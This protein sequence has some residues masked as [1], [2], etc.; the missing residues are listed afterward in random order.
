MKNLLFLLVFLAPSLLQGQVA[1]DSVALRQVDSLLQVVF[2]LNSNRGFD[3]ALQILDSI[4]FSVIEKAGRESVQ[5][6]TWLLHRGFIPLSKGDNKGSEK[7]LLE[8]ESIH[9]H[10]LQERHPD[11]FKVLYRLG[12]FVY[13]R[14]NDSL[15]ESY[16]MR[17]KAF[18]E[19]IDRRKQIEYSRVLGALGNFYAQT[20]KLDRA[21]VIMLESLASIEAMKGRENT[22]YTLALENL[23]KIYTK[24]NRFPEA[25]AKLTE[26]R[27]IKAKTLGTAHPDYAYCLSTMGNNYKETGEFEQAQSLYEQ[28]LRITEAAYGQNHTQY[29]AMLESMAIFYITVLDDLEQGEQLLSTARE[30]IGNLPA[31]KAGFSYYNVTKNLALLYIEMGEFKKSESLCDEVYIFYAAMGK[32]NFDYLSLRANMAILYDAQQRYEAAEQACQEVM[33]VEKK[34]TGTQ[35]ELY[36]KTCLV[37]G[38]AYIGQGAYIRAEKALL[39]AVDIYANI[40]GKE[41]LSYGEALTNLAETCQKLAQYDR[42]EQYYTEAL[43]VQEKVSGK[44]HSDRLATLQGLA[45]LYTERRQ[46]EQAEIHWLAYNQLMR[47][48][49]GKSATYM[50]EQ[51][52]LAYLKTFEAGINAFN[53]FVQQHPVPQ[54]CA[55]TYDNNLLFNGLLLENARRL[56]VETDHA[57]SLTQKTYMRWQTCQRYLAVQYAKPLAERKRVAETEEEA[58][59]LEKDL[60]RR[61]AA[62]AGTRQVPRWQAIQ[63]A[64]TPDKVAI[65]W[66][67]YYIG[68]GDSTLY[69][70]LILL[71]GTDAPLFIPL[72]EEK[73]LTALLQAKGRLQPAF[74]NE[75]Y[76]DD[77]KGSELYDLIWKPIAAVL[78][79][80]TTVYC[81]PS[82]LLHRLNL[83]AIPTPDGNTLGKKYRLTM[84]GSTRQLVVPPASA[85]NQ[86]ATAQ[87]YGGIQYGA[88]PALADKTDTAFTDLV[89]V[90]RGPDF[91]QNDSTLR[92]DN[93]N[94]LRWTEVE[95]SAAAEVMKGKG[96]APVLKKGAEATE[97][98]FKAIGTTGPSPRILHVATHGFFFPDPAPSVPLEGGGRVAS[99]SQPLKVGWGGLVSENPMIRSGLVLAGGN[100]AWKTGKP[101]RL[102]L[103][104]GILTAYEISQMNLVN[105]ELVV[106]SACET[107]L[108]D[109]VGNEGVYGL[110]R[111]F[112]IA[113][114]RYLI[115]SLWQ[116][117]DFQTQVFISA[118][119]KHWLEG[120]MTIPEAFRATQLEL[121]TEYDEAFKWAAFVLVE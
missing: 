27:D 25:I 2:N 16:L 85:T 65:E 12:A 22:D 20:G 51:Q 81:S 68:S 79:K 69:A 18:L 26:S 33:I 58:G 44:Q 91:T 109:L 48:L 52:M 116:V 11:Y 4:Q 63:S 118:F 92:G 111:A 57:D 56:M 19:K 102:D 35:T 46:M 110:Q 32:E 47:Q 14:T 28:A 82:G 104:D 84:L 72:F 101:L 66:V 121:K 113:G 36:A 93:W 103:E 42:A 67:S 7:W 54:F 1:V 108:G 90:R 55:L 59:N 6:A 64:L 89:A 74:Y 73:Q 86:N 77:K 76:K 95:I 70:A 37:L 30:I 120:K 31:G 105:T 71:P 23:S 80:G 106:L 96:I 10:H 100:H 5:Y 99:P 39:E 61:L 9:I 78:P 41:N 24:K 114:A 62:F 3:R 21:E 15:C 53:H 8:A 94:Y 34:R 117:P 75:L 29:A 83:S 98:S 50:S 45:R 13:Y 87:L 38:K 40:F 60:T 43:H 17:G 97:E 107:G 112:K 119:Y 88:S 115:M 49:V